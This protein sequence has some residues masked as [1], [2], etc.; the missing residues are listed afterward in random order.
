MHEATP[1]GFLRAA[2]VT[3]ERGGPIRRFEA[4]TGGDSQMGWSL[5]PDWVLIG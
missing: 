4:E 3:P 2:Q 5:L 1:Q